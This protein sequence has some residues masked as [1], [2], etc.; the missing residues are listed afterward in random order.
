CRERCETLAVGFDLKGAEVTLEGVPAY[1]LRGKPRLLDIMRSTLGARQYRL[2]MGI[3]TFDEARLKEMGRAAFGTPE[4]FREVVELGHK[5][6]FTTSADLLFNLPGQSLDEMK[7]D[8][9]KAL[10]LGLDHVGLYHLV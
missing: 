1:F 5:L 9:R 6:G 10:D 3:Q 7:D 2:S 4:T 8:L